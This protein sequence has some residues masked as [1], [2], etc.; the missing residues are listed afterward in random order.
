MDPLELRELTLA[1]RVESTYRGNFAQNYA[2]GRYRS[3]TRGPELTPNA[4]AIRRAVDSDGEYQAC[5]ISPRAWHPR[6]LESEV[7]R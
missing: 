5:S 4:T 6:E 3:V 1:V 7:L 2:P